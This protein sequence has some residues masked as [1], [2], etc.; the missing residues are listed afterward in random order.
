MLWKLPVSSTNNEM[1]CNFGLA[2]YTNLSVCFRLIMIFNLTTF[3]FW[4]SVSQHMH[5][6]KRL[7]ESS[8]V[9]FKCVCGLPIACSQLFVL[10][11]SQFALGQCC[12]RCMAAVNGPCVELS[13]RAAGWSGHNITANTWNLTSTALM[14][15]GLWLAWNQSGRT[16]WEVH[17][18]IGS[19]WRGRSKPSYEISCEL[20]TWKTLP[21]SR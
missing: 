7:C 3:F 19:Q 13:Y 21:Q 5:S 4:L 18:P 17:R 10:F 6:A 1:Q 11:H 8:S 15:G 12:R 20:R 14:N 9:T 16:P 2:A